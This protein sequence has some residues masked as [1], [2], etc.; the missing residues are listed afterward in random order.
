MGSLCSISDNF[1]SDESYTTVHGPA[2][3]SNNSN[4]PQYFFPNITKRGKR[5]Y[6][7]DFTPLDFCDE[8]VKIYK[9]RIPF[10]DSAALQ[11]ISNISYLTGNGPYHEGLIF[12][13]KYNNFYI[14]QSYPITFVKVKNFSQG[15]SDIISFNNFNNTSRSYKIPEIYLPTMP[16]TVIDIYEII[17]K[18]PNQYHIFT[19][20]CQNFV[21]NIVES[22]KNKYNIIV[23]NNLKKIEECLCEINLKKNNRNVNTNKNLEEIKE[24]ENEQMLQSYVDE[25]SIYLI[26]IFEEKNRKK[27]KNSRSVGNLNF[28]G[29]NYNNNNLK[30]NNLKQ[31]SKNL[32]LSNSYSNLLKY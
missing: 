2:K 9:I 29:K 25:D 18:L 7:T 12:H 1:I 28:F 10:F 19:E 14:A 24:N 6:L 16:I 5:K 20:N 8:I 27:L 32:V 30:E 4:H 21:S 23:E 15:I 3:M 26:N 31:K 22:L 17:N 11:T 13:S